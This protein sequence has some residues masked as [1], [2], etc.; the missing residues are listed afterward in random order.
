MSKDTVKIVRA[1]SA[2]SCVLW[3]DR[4]AMPGG[5]PLDVSVAEAANLM[6]RDPADWQVPAA[7]DGALVKA[8]LKRRTDAAK[9][10]ADE[11]AKAAAP[12]D[13]AGGN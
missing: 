12:A 9:K 13:A 7:D 4:K 2:P 5:D 10:A 8:E 11:A 3:D 1:K 6:E